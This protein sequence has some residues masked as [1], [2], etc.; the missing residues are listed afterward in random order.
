[1][2]REY[3]GPVSRTIAYV[4]DA[5][6]VAVLFTGAIAVAGVIAT[7]LGVQELTRAVASG[8]LLVLP[9]LLACYHALFWALAGRT[10]AMA[11]LGLRVVAVRSAHLSWPSAVVR[12]VVLTCFPIGAVWA[13]V[14]RRRQAVHDKLARTVMI[15]VV[16]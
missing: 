5:V 11:L 2:S 8:Y 14:D 4:L 12:A 13:L 16:R 15:R 7:V 3:A 1:M 10:P 6:I 9:T